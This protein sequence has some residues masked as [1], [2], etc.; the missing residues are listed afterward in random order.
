MNHSSLA[1]GLKF[2][3]LD[4]ITFGFPGLVLLIGTA[5]VGIYFDAGV[6]GSILLGL[7]LAIL[8]ASIV[9]AFGYVS[10]SKRQ[11]AV[12][13]RFG[14]VRLVLFE[15]IGWVNPLFD[16]LN[17]SVGSLAMKE[18]RLY[19]DEPGRAEMDFTDASAPVHVK[20]A[21][22]VGRPEDADANNWEALR[23]AVIAF[24]Y[25]YSNPE[26][27]I[28]TILDGE[29]RPRLQAMSI[30][31]AQHS[32]DEACMA[33]ALA[34]ADT[35]STFGVYQP[36]QSPIVVEDIDLP[37]SVVALRQQV[38]EGE[39]EAERDALQ[40]QG[41]ARAIVAVREALTDAGVSMSDEDIVKFLLTQQGLDTISKTG[42]NI[43]LV[44]PDVEGLLK[45]LG[46]GGK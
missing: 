11:Y 17:G 34:A 44:S 18:I 43:T 40:L 20:S 25:T 29:L 6:I 21:Y 46:V 22:S 3:I 45:T 8:W 16:R 35:L 36:A 39:K 30:D 42:A 33:A 41:P 37:E 13:E 4:W 19:T 7:S 5:A 15:G 9:F 32:N 10:I 38:L 26:S 14:K 27:R 12:Y 31:D 1:W 28:E 23:D 2:T 24:T